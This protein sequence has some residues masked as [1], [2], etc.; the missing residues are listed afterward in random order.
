MAEVDEAKKSDAALASADQI[1]SGEG[2]FKEMSEEEVASRMACLNHG[3]VQMVA[4]IQIEK[5]VN[6]LLEL[7][8]K[9]KNM[10]DRLISVHEQCDTIRGNASGCSRTTKTSDGAKTV[11]LTSQTGQK[12]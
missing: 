10:R 4:N 11:P 8:L 3:E 7:T 6:K 2:P 5:Q 12:M 1:F 9:A